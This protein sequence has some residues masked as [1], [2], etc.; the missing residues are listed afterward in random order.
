[1]V[2]A[3][4]AGIRPFFCLRVRPKLERTGNFSEIRV[5][6]LGLE[7]LNMLKPLESQNIVQ[8]LSC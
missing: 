5:R 7:R 6:G 4:S 3:K 1:M 2:G 8:L